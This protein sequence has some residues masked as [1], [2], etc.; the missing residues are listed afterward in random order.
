[1]S[2]AKVHRVSVKAMVVHEGRL[3][4]IKKADE[5]GVYYIFPGGGQEHGEA[6]TET[7]I[8]EVREETGL[9][10]APGDLIVVRDYIGANHEFRETS[11]HFHQVELYFS[12]SLL[13]SGHAVA[14]QPDNGQ[15][16]LEW[17]PLEQVATSRIY[18]LSLREVFAAR[19]APRIYA[20]DVN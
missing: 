20:G 11:S 2:P 1:M 18:P 8:R 12:A 6:L 15:I 3:L 16:G 7:L 19:S 10:V 5:S 9:A 13:A 17:L 14:T 4:L